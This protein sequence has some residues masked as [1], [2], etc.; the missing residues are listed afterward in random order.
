MASHG[1]STLNSL[2]FP[3]AAKSRSIREID[4]DGVTRILIRHRFAES[5]RVSL[6]RLRSDT[7]TNVLMPSLVGSETAG[8]DEDINLKGKDYDITTL[9]KSILDGSALASFGQGGGDFLEEGATSNTNIKQCLRKVADGHFKAAVKVLSSFGVAPHCDD[10]I[11]ALEAKHPYKPPPS[12]PSITFSKPPLVAEIDS[13]FSCIKSFPKGTSCGRD[14]LRAQH[15]LDALCGEGSATATDLL[16]VITSVVNLW[17]A[18]RCPPILA[19]FVASAP[20]TP[21]LKPDNGIR[22]IAVGTIWRRLVSKVAMKGV[23]KEMSKYLSD[24]QF[25]VGVSGG[26]EAI[27]HSVNRVL[28]EY[29]NDGSLAMLTVDFSNAFNLVDRSALLHEV[30]VK[31]PSISLW[32]DFLYGQASRLYIGDTH[33]WSATGVQQGDPL[34]PLLFALILHP[35]LHKIKDSCKLLLHAWYLDDGTVIGDSEEVARVL[36]IIKVSG[37]GLGLELNIKKT[38]IFWPSCNGMKLR[39]GLFPVDIRRPSSGLKLLGGAISKDADFI[40]GLAIRR[41]ANVVDLMGLLPQLHDPHSE[42]FLLRSCMGIA[43]L[44]F[45]LRTCQPVHMEEAT[46]FFN[47]GLR[48]SIE[49]IVVCGGPFLET[50]CLKAHT[51]G[52]TRHIYVDDSAYVVM[53]F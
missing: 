40:S 41:A 33:I 44:F 14:G 23:G 25:G 5:S 1:S 24:F 8:K 21:L 26:A 31:C 50:Y 49:N 29:H 39:E 2:R 15:I 19:E 48:G 7:V 4:R 52:A 34:G 45:G 42:L 12:M 6:R 30:R 32:V 18:G 13:V 46:L 3:S 20:L 35:L 37:P 43:K 27:L 22:P 38:K 16:K 10:T 28:S 47:K 36:D 17:L 53:D 11:K 51:L 9:V